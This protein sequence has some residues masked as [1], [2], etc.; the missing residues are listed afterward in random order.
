MSAADANAIKPL[1]SDL[2]QG[3]NIKN[4]QSESY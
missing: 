3:P 1:P 4:S 2:A